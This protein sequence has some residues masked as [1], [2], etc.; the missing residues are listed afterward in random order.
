MIDC[1]VAGKL[2]GTP[3]AKTGK[4]GKPFTVAKVRAATADAE[5][6]FVNV[7]A[8]SDTAQVAL[9]ALGDQDAVSLAGT[10]TPKVWTDRNGQARPA[11]DMVA[12]QVMTAYSVTRKR[13]AMQPEQQ[14][15]EWQR[16]PHRHGDY[17]ALTLASWSRATPSRSERGTKGV[18]I[19]YTLHPQTRP[20]A[21]FV[22]PGRAEM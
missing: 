14:E 5:T 17:A 10:V 7:V 4:S 21:G 1:I 16:Q 18:A 6:I 3:Q 8:F 19:S 15:G 20:S 11:L 22:A 13:K 12:A 9:Q 2:F